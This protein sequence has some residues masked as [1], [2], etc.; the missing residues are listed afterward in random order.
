[1]M[2]SMYEHDS[3]NL[4]YVVHIIELSERL[5]WALLDTPAYVGEQK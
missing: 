1:M 2:K 4:V 3:S 5:V